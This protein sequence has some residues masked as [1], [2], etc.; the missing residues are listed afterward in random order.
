VSFKRNLQGVIEAK[1]SLQPAMADHRGKNIPRG[2]DPSR[3][4]ADDESEYEPDITGLLASVKASISEDIQRLQDAQQ[5]LQDAQTRQYSELVRNMAEIANQIAKI[6]T[7]QGTIRGRSDTEGRVSALTEQVKKLTVGDSTTTSNPVETQGPRSTDF[8]VLAAKELAKQSL[9]LPT[10]QKLVGPENYEQWLQAVTIQFTALDIPHFV[11][12]PETL[13]AGC[14]IS[15]RAGLL[16]VLRRTIADGPL[17]TISYITDP[18]IA[19]RKLQQQYQPGAIAHRALLYSEFHSIQYTQGTIVDFNAKFLALISRLKGLGVNLAT[20]DCIN[21]YF[22]ALQQH[23]PQWVERARGFY[24]GLIY[25]GERAVIPSQNQLD[26]FMNDILEESRIPKT[27]ISKYMNT[28]NVKASKKGFKN[29]H[30]KR[31]TNHFDENTEGSRNKRPPKQTH[32]PTRLGREKVSKM[33][34]SNSYTMAMLL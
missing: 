8:S 30:F 1:A 29:K 4:D 10:E 7:S 3:M 25:S 20:Q 28:I 11:S 24:W 32:K 34:E 21:Q 9:T 19:F 14:T 26:F 27:S 6:S 2:Q 31:E 13:V 17:A 33:T 12:D 5:R 16:L 18:A 22:K 23:F 15:A